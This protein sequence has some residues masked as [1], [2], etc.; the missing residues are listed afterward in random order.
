MRRPLF[1]VALLLT[2]SC[3]WLV[4]GCDLG[5]GSDGD[6]DVT[7]GGDSAVD[8]GWVTPGESGWQEL[9]TALPC[10]PNALWFDDRQNGF[11]GC[12]DKAEG[13]G[14]WST[15][16]GGQT[17]QSHAAFADIRINDIRRGPD[18]KLYGA[19]QFLAEESPVFTIDEGATDLAATGLYTWGD[20][21]HTKVGQ[22]ENV[23][24]TANGQILIDSLTGTT[25]A[26]KAAGGDFVE[27]H[28]LGEEQITDL[29]P[30]TDDSECGS[31]SCKSSAE[32]GG[33]DPCCQ[34]ALAWQLRS[35]V[36]YD[37]AFY[38]CGSL[39]NDPARVRLP[40]RLDGAT[41]H[42]ET[43][44]L[45]DESE[46]G[47]L[48]DMH[49]WSQTRMIVVG[50]DQSGTQPL[51]F[52]LNGDPY[53]KANWTQVSLSDSG[54]D[55]AGRAFAVSAAGDNVVVVGEKSPSSKGGFI[56]ASSDG[57]LTWSDVTPQTDLGKIASLEQVWTFAN[58]DI[59]ALGET[60]WLYVD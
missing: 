16:D 59:V 54:I 29:A 31:G 40:S 51:I 28:G 45:Q 60:T 53:Q 21:A 41:Y 4:A 47:E 20:K 11:I 5:L 52:V 18:G 27:L 23:A 12:G 44:V 2:F 1:L 19:G 58:G 7:T 33:T 56:I 48:L 15:W 55:W 49:L 32:C 46:D 34:P 8:P 17:W 37:N 36:A 22:A 39:I 42:F 6:D 14:L 57:G 9:K 38:G 50:S 13:A 25:G 24:V 26:Y 3:V 43:V 30:C 35:I 10:R